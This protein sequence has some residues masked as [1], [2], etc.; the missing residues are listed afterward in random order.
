[1]SYSSIMADGHGT[2]QIPK[3]EKS[4]SGGY[5]Y[6]TPDRTQWGAS[7]PLTSINDCYHGV[8]LENVAL[9][10]P[11]TRR[12]AISLWCGESGCHTTEVWAIAA[13]LLGV[14]L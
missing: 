14:S 3:A 9:W 8:L 11:P 12:A 1:M 13:R 5:P 6:S 10:P 7:E 4:F 2:G